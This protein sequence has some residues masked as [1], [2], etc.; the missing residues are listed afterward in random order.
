MKEALGEQTAQF[1]ATNFENN[2]SLIERAG[3]T[4]IT[5]DKIIERMNDKNICYEIKLAA[6]KFEEIVLTLRAVLLAAQNSGAV[7]ENTAFA[8]ITE[9]DREK[10]KISTILEGYGADL[11]SGYVF[12]HIK[13]N[14]D[15]DS[16]YKVEFCID[17]N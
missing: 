8:I 7:F 5:L 1:L 12:H 17:F 4:S 2:V 6:V 14:S 11:K 13:D 10:K 16:L 3:S 9:N 15:G